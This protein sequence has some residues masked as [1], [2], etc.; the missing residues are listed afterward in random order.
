MAIGKAMD[1]SSFCLSANLYEPYH[2]YV[3]QNL[4][5]YYNSSYD[6]ENEMKV[7]GYSDLLIFHEVM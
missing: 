7:Q 4:R 5:N 6:M 3:K 1:H 2:L